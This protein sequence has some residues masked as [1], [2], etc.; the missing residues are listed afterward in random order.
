MKIND[1]S[2]GGYMAILL[3]QS[4]GNTNRSSIVCEYSI[5]LEHIQTC[6]CASFFVSS[7]F[8]KIQNAGSKLIQTLSVIW[9][10]L[11]NQVKWSVTYIK[12]AITCVEFIVWVKI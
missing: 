10:K 8:L 4:C 3:T 2:D 1:Q 9:Y 12:Y 5:H 7:Q 11:L 6:K